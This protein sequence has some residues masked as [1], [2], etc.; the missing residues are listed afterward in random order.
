MRYNGSVPAI[1]YYLLSVPVH[2][3]GPNTVDRQAEPLSSGWGTGLCHVTR[4]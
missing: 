4:E 1:V 2:I 3:L